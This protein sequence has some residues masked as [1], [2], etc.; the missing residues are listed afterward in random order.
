MTVTKTPVLVLDSTQP[1]QLADFYAALLHAEVRVGA[2]PDFVEVAGPDGVRLAVR[3]D[4]GYAP[5]S[6]PRPEDSQQSHLYIRVAEGD[7]DAAEREAVGLGA[8]PVD[9]GA[10]PGAGNARVYAD[11][12]GH[13]FTLE[14]V[15]HT[16]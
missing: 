10:G 8:T 15:P 2:D 6:W 1:R 11:P 14:A 3:R 13:S 5:P 16:A 9:S 12:A 4:H 7:L